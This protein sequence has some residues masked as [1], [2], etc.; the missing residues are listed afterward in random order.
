M[1][2]LS[3]FYGIGVG[4]YVFALLALKCRPAGGASHRALGSRLDWR[5]RVTA[6][7]FGP[8]GFASMIYGLLVL[9]AGIRD[10]EHVFHL[11]AI[12]IAGSMIAHS[13]TDVLV[14]RWFATSASPHAR[15]KIS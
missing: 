5:E 1:I 12:V 11:I 2:S 4:G 8:K 14:A 6:A 10:A 9:H 7:W 3:Y 15:K 13:S